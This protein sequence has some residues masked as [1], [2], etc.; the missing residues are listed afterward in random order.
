[1]KRELNFLPT[2][3]TTFGVLSVRN[4]SGKCKNY[5]QLSLPLIRKDFTTFDQFPII[6]FSFRPLI[7]R[8]RKLPYP[9]WRWKKSNPT[10]Y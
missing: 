9:K 10:M 8:R 3:H 6:N 2:A 1:M 7:D 5:W 4:S